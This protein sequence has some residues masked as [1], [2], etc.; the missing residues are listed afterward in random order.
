MKQENKTAI[1][2]LCIHNTVIRIQSNFEDKKKL[3]E[4]LF[5]IANSRLKHFT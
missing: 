4:I 5:S 3:K 1:T 2:I